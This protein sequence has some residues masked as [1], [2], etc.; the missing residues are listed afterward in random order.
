MKITAIKIDK[1]ELQLLD[2]TDLPNGIPIQFSFLC[3]GSF[4]L[5][6]VTGTKQGNLLKDVHKN[7]NDN[8]WERIPP[9]K[10]FNLYY[11]L[12]WKKIS[13][14]IFI[15][16][17]GFS[18][19]IYLLTLFIPIGLLQPNL[20]S[21]S[22]SPETSKTSPSNEPNQPQKFPEQGWIALAILI[23]TNMDWLGL[24]KLSLNLMNGLNLETFQEKLDEV[25]EGQE[26]NQEDIHRLV[27][28]LLKNSLN[29]E[30]WEIIDHLYH[31]YTHTFK[32]TSKLDPSNH[33]PEI[34]ENQFR[35]LRNLG[36][37][38]RKD[39]EKLEFPY[40]EMEYKDI[41]KFIILTEEAIMNIQFIRQVA[42]KEQC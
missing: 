9:G 38:V 26:K 32:P 24:N 30:E 6:N 19:L 40:Q 1:D 15:K 7:S 27:G 12:S 25:G 5:S 18:S 8:E 34:P 3:D 11:N 16:L 10:V 20:N 31:N 2:D 23:L 28:F 4:F 42:G 22:P 37:I 29:K 21:P 33:D 41:N 17:L 39:G 35:R 13:R 14:T 36:L